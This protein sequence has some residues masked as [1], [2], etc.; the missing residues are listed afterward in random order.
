M[1]V[2]SFDKDINLCTVRLFG[3]RDHEFRV[4]L[5]IK[6]EQNKMVIVD[7]REAKFLSRHVES[8][9]GNYPGFDIDF[10]TPIALK[11]NTR[12]VFRADINGPPSWFGEGGQCW[13]NHSGVNFYFDNSSRE[14]STCVERGQFSEFLFTID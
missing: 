11:A 5:C 3:S 4:T 9:M 10:V 13:V 14:V 6:V 1:I 8:E 12:Y 7:T 2:L